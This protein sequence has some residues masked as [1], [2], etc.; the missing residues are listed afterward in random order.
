MDKVELGLKI[1][2]ARIQ[3]GLTQEKLAESAG[4][5]AVYLSEIERGLKMPSLNL[6]VKLIDALDISADY[7]LRDELSTGKEYVYDEVIGKLEDLTPK[8]RKA[9]A[10]IID[11]FVATL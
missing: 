8:Q 7:I 1:K 5:G 2:E 10:A 6:F 4:V 11:A 3:K 9:A